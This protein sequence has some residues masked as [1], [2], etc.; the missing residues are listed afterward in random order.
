MCGT[1]LGCKLSVYEALISI[2]FIADREVVHDLANLWA[3]ERSGMVGNRTVVWCEGG[4]RR[5]GE[6][7]TQEHKAF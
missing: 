1:G 7:T 5:E 4:L 6:N 3:L 2:N